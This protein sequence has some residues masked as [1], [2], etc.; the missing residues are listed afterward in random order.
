MKEVSVQSTRGAGFVLAAGLALV[1][2]AD[3][4]FAAAS[5]YAEYQLQ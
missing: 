4:G 1:L 3:A 2:A 5:R